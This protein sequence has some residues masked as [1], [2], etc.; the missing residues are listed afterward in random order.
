[1]QG[2]RATQGCVTGVTPQHAVGVQHASGEGVG[3][4]GG[5]IAFG[6]VDTRVRPGGCGEQ[7]RWGCL[8]TLVETFRHWGVVNT[9]LVV[10]LWWFQRGIGVGVVVEVIFIV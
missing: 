8:L 4:G 2:L 3:M 10:V 9:S 1:M 5:V 7:R 6:I